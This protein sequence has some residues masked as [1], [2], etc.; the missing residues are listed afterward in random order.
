MCPARVPTC[1]NT[2]EKARAPSPTRAA[3]GSAAPARRRRWV[4]RPLCA[5]P[6]AEK[7][8]G[9]VARQ[10]V[11]L[12]NTHASHNRRRREGPVKHGHNGRCI[13]RQATCVGKDPGINS[14]GRSL[15]S[16][17]GVHGERLEIWRG[18]ARKAAPK[19]PFRTQTRPSFGAT[20]ASS[21]EEPTS[22]SS[23]T[24]EHLAPNI[25]RIRALSAEFGTNVRTT[26]AL[27]F[28][29]LPGG[30]LIDH[31]WTWPGAAPR[32]S[33]I[34]LHN[35]RHAGF[36]RAKEAE[37]ADACM[38][39]GASRQASETAPSFHVAGPTQQAGG[40]GARR[41]VARGRASANRTTCMF[42]MV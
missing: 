29:P 11:A 22:G 19:L 3:I 28:G 31:R 9:S 39:Q 23:R 8:C 16:I 32:G 24:C 36:R 15:R 14:T 40:G 33:S 12:L 37:V 34:V 6:C 21:C 2:T 35:Q 7:S 27:D 13:S 4:G 42:D 38:R 25:S 5:T 17:G 18:G 30:P 10:R 41:G 1:C 20:S 26:L